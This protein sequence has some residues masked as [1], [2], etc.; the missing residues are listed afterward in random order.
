MVVLGVA[1]TLL[2]LA[3]TAVTLAIPAVL[4]GIAQALVFPS[5][6]AL[7]SVSVDEENFGLGMGLMGTLKYAGKVA[8][9]SLAGVLIYWLDFK[10]AFRLMAGVLLAGALMVWFVAHHPRRPATERRARLA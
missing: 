9:P 1:L 5:T 10:S 8:G 7:V 4:M 3:E 6:V 2:T